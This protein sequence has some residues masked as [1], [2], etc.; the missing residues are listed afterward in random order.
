[1]TWIKPSFLWMMYRSSWGCAVGQE[2]VLAIR[3]RRDGFEW[4]LAH[5][6]LSGYDGSVHT[7]R[8]QR[9]REMRRS[10]VRVQWDPERDLS[11]QPMPRRSL[12]VGLRGE[13][14]RCYLDEIVGIDDVT[15]LA[16]AVH[17]LA[18][19]G[20]VDHS[21]DARIPDDEPDTSEHQKHRPPAASPVS[22]HRFIRRSTSAR[23][24]IV[25]LQREPSGR[26]TSTST[27]QTSSSPSSGPRRKSAP[28]GGIVAAGS[29]DNHVADCR[30][31]HIIRCHIARSVGR[32]CRS[33]D[34]GQLG[35]GSRGKN[36]RHHTAR[37]GRTSE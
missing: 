33:G 11:L 28:E 3:I 19:A 14:V 4:A 20:H 24:K 23:V 16:H 25:A 5:S 36:D 15:E 32:L 17:E 8:D 13:A 34:A 9:K 6:A 29:S 2:R 31:G 1:M 30:I 26:R 27:L 7:S 12:Q 10:P 18:G 21:D 22:S 37:S 35:A